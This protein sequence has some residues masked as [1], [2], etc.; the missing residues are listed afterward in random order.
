MMS[1]QLDEAS[2][3]KILSVRQSE[4]FLLEECAQS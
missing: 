3:M 2:I 1:S 4:T